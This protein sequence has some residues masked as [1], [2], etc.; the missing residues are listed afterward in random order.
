MKPLNNLILKLSMKHIRSIPKLAKSF[1]FSYKQQKY[2]LSEYLIDILYVLKT[3][4]ALRD[5][6]SHINW[7]SVYK[8]YVKLNSFN[9]FK[10]SYIA[11]LKKYFKKTFNNKLK[12]VK[13]NIL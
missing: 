4:I 1:D 10:L 6:R 8:T 7:N 9:I 2:N 3:G 11:I 5:L 13:L 12:M